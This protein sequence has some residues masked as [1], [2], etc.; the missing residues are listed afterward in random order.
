VS[1]ASSL[2]GVVPSAASDASV[3][4]A[5][6]AGGLRRRPYTVHGP[7]YGRNAARWCV[8][9]Q[10]CASWKTWNFFAGGTSFLGGSARRRLLRVPHDLVARTPPAR[11]LLAPFARVGAW[12][13]RMAAFGHGA[14]SAIDRAAAFEQARRAAATHARW[15]PAWPERSDPRLGTQ[16]EIVPDDYGRDA[17]A[18]TLVAISDRHVTVER[19]AEGIG[20]A[21][22]HFP[23]LGY[24]LTS[25]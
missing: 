18:G 1:R 13:D 4:A 17:L 22:I 7:V 15:C 2:L 10:S 5:R 16:V 14:P 8:R 23:R 19:E 6:H 11:D 3:L 24:E 21:R 9:A 25:L 20:R 12:A